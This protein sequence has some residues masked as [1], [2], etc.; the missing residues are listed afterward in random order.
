MG[1]GWDSGTGVGQED[2]RRDRGTR[3]GKVKTVEVV[4]W[5]R[6]TRDVIGV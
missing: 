5:D 4:E 6:G 1:L 2:Y 3:D